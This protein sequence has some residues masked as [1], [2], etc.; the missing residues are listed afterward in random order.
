MVLVL[1]S[2]SLVS[3]TAWTVSTLTGGGSPFIL[4]PLVNILLGTSAIAPVVGTGMLVANFQRSLWFWQY[5]NWSVTRW[6][7]PGAILGAILG[8]YS[9]TQINLEWLPRILGLFLLFMVA[10]SFIKVKNENIFQVSAWQFLP[11]GFIYAFISGLIGSSGPIMNPFYLNYGL[12]KEEMIGTKA[13]NILVL[14][15]VKILSYY[16]LGILTL[17]Y[18]FYGLL[19]GVSTLPANWVSQYVLRKMSNKQFKLLVLSF[20]AGSGIIMLF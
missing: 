20:M 12:L 11:A 17:P 1:F 2:L 16:S 8:A 4:I 5:T 6:Y 14:H 10:L 15:L 19:I 18:F 3:F 13:T 7:L 9:L